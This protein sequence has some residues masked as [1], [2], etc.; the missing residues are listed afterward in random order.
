M[1]RLLQIRRGTAAQW[2]SANPTLAV[3]EPGFETDTGYVKVGDG[4]TAWT[5]L[6][7]WRGGGAAA[8]LST[9]T[10]AADK[11][12]YY[13]SGSAAALADLSTYMRG[14]LGSANEAALKAAINAEAGTDFQAYDAYLQDISDM[15]PTSG[16]VVTFDGVNMVPLAPLTGQGIPDAVI[17]HSE[18]SGTAGG[19]QTTGSWVVRKMDLEY[20]PNSVVSISSNVFTFTADGWVEWAAKF[21]A[22][23]NIRMRLYNVTDSAVVTATP[24][25]LNSFTLANSEQIAVGH[26]PVVAGKAYQLEQFS[27]LTVATN[28]QG[29]ASS[30]GTEIYAQVKFWKA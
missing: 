26:A 19:T 14:L 30:F 28:G 24:M 7:Y 25:S 20:D 23:N 3:G 27:G 2:T 8:A 29:I 6:A 22:N 9:V 11:I 5:S 18:T 16:D 10:P 13:T 12:A 15:S 17:Y 21:Y 1:A 4:A